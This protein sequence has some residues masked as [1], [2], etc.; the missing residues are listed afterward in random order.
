M[1]SKWIFHILWLIIAIKDIRQ[2][3]SADIGICYGTLGDNLPPPTEVVA[4]FKQYN[5]GKMRLYDPNL[6]IL[7]ALRGQEI[8][9]I[10]GVRNEDVQ[11]MASSQS[12]AE[13]WVLK[14]VVNYINDI[15]F[16]FFVVGNEIV[17]GELA[18]FIAPAMQNLLNALRLYSFDG[19]RVTTSVASTVLQNSYPPSA[20]EFT[21]NSLGP[22]TEILKVL[23]AQSCPVLMINAYPYFAYAGDPINVNLDFAQFTAT[24]PVVID[25]EFQYMNLL[26]AIVDGFYWAIEKAGNFSDITVG[27]SES[28]WPSAGN[29][30]LTSPEL[31][32]VYN[33]NFVKSILDNGGTPKRP[34]AYM[35]AFL[36]AMFNENLK[37]VGVEQN[38][39]LFYP[40]KE[41]VYPLFPLS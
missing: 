17:P 28:G 40:N 13:S 37:P 32:S 19:I 16:T 22:I 35:E 38:W 3:T 6:D 2:S 26:D 8:E 21:P 18:Q 20:S 15:Q 30:R 31:A 27:I 24:S 25:G 7:E 5:V 41:P 36:F 9:V 12:A 4:L 11:I 29:G 1:A 39:G 23:S 34:F 10:L 33:K 14:N